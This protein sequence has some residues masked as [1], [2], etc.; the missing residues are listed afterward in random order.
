MTVKEHVQHVEQSRNLNPEPPFSQTYFFIFDTSQ[1][2]QPFQG[3]RISRMSTTTV[4]EWWDPCSSPVRSPSEFSI[5][6]GLHNS[7]CPSFDGL[8]YI[9]LYYVDEIHINTD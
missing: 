8:Y 2:K 3:R 7:A 1:N 5:T 4:G 6:V 9:I